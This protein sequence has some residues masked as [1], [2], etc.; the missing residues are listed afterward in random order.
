[1][2][3]TWYLISY[4]HLDRPT[5]PH[6]PLLYFPVCAGPFSTTPM[7]RLLKVA[8]LPAFLDQVFERFPKLTDLSMMRN[9]A[10]P[11]LMD[12]QRP[13][14]EA[15]RM[16]RTY[17]VFRAQTLVTVDG[18]HVTDEVC[19]RRQNMLRDGFRVF[20]LYGGGVPTLIVTSHFGLSYLYYVYDVLIF[21]SYSRGFPARWWCA[22][23]A[24]P[25]YRGKPP[26][27]L[28]VM[29]AIPQ[30]CQTTLTALYGDT[31]LLRSPCW[32]APTLWLWLDE[33]ARARLWR[34]VEP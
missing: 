10:C 13:D 32:G 21:C 29:S 2:S 31:A 1:M 16:Y 5:S 18:V 23:A 9:P 30:S 25:P 17:V 6:L 19:S 8:N 14:M 12:I 7:T 11:G 27:S 33:Y 34:A 15:C 24:W 22:R 26:Y 3:H 20:S 28:Q 4:S